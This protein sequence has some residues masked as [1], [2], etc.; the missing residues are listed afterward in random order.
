MTIQLDLFPKSEMQIISDQVMDM[1]KSMDKTRRLLM[2]RINDLENTV[3]AL[4][5]ELE[6]ISSDKIE[7]VN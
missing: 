4:E 2:H 7:N 3:L 1:K 5:K 6:E